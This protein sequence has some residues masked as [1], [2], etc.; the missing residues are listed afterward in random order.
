[1]NAGTLA[2]L[3]QQELFQLALKAGGSG[4]AGA[5]I[6]Y[7]KE[8]VSRPDATAN[9]HYMLG[10]EYAQ[11]QMYDR[12]ADELEAA[13]A[14]D[15]ALATARL[16]LGLLWLGAG[17]GAR[18]AGVLQPLTEGGVAEALAYFGAGLLHLIG[19]DLPAARASLLAGIALNTSNAPLN[20]DMQGIVAEIDARLG[21]AQPAA[22]ASE[23]PEQE[24]GSHHL[25]LSAYA[26]NTT[27]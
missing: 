23:E 20:A 11:L 26:G 15:P 25:F 6:A 16:Q 14:L 12:A 19:D 13:L 27:H 21:G 3:D 24:D 7:L 10:A 18:A 4:D 17:D 22:P 5:A 9:A 8:A 1:M 2:M